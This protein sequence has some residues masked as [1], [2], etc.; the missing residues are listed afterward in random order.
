[1]GRRGAGDGHR[2]V[3]RPGATA[4]LTLWAEDPVAA[5]AD[6][7]TQISVLMTTIDGKIVHNDPLVKG[8][9]R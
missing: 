4:D 6:E 5:D 3:I 8:A 9:A 7:L 2:G 1:M